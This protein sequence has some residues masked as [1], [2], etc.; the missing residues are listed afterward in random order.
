MYRVADYLLRELPQIAD[1]PPVEIIDARGG[2]LALS[3]FFITAAFAKIAF[4]CIT[5]RV[6]LVHIHMAERF[7]IFRKGILIAC[8]RAFG[9]PTV[10]HLHASRL[11][12][13]YTRMPKPLRW[14]A[15][16]VF[17]LPTMTVVLGDTAYHYVVEQL[18]S[19]PARVVKIPNGVPRACRPHVARAGGEPF[20]LLFLGNMT[21]RKGVTDLLLALSTPAMLARD[22]N[23]TM[24][25]GG[26]VEHYR[27]KVHELGLADRVTMPGWIDNEQVQRL[28]SCANAL[29]L[30]SY[31]E[32]LPMVILEAL[33]AGVPV[34]CTPVGEIPQFLESDETALFVEPGNPSSIA[35]ALCRLMDEPDLAKRL[36]VAAKAL[37]ERTFSLEQFARSVA[38]VYERCGMN[39][40]GK[41]PAAPESGSGSHSKVE[42]KLSA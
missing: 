24:A 30:P 5:G 26:E 7:S 25:G 23:I 41:A 16:K 2:R 36:T 4:G 10:L 28:L 9:T 14:L 39:S 19:D 3:P 27:A 34:V 32:A 12:Q 6:A 42:G 31:D 18:G 15:R 20:R 35:G 21:E 1:I 13:E 37:Y 17:S 40:L 8:A 29:L 33:T 11:T 38:A 22:W